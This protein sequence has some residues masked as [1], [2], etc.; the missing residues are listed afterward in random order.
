MDNKKYVMQFFFNPTYKDS[1]IIEKI[2]TVSDYISNYLQVLY[3]NINYSIDEGN[4]SKTHSCEYSAKTL[5]RIHECKY[6]DITAISFEKLKK[7][8]CFMDSDITLEFLLSNKD[9]FPTRMKLL[10]DPRIQKDFSFSKLNDCI[11]FMTSLGLE[12]EY[13]MGLVLDQEKMPNLFLTGIKTPNLSNEEKDIVDALALNI[14]EYK[15]K[16]WDVFA[17]NVIKKNIVSSKMIKDIN[18]MISNNILF[19]TNSFYIISLHNDIDSFTS[20]ND[21]YG[22][23]KQILRNIFSNENRIMYKA[24]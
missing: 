5:E 19:E 16:I 3:T 1:T 8:K 13:G 22:K 21:K 11:N 9:D 12:L 24:Q 20:N 7:K 10:V 6:S 23:E 2:I 18:Q 15:T 4:K 17:Y 14:R